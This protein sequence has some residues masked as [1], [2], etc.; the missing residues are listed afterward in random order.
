MMW[1][2]PSSR[3]RAREVEVYELV[4]AGQR[5]ETRQR[6]LRARD[7]WKRRTSTPR[8]LRAPDPVSHL[9]EQQC[10]LPLPSS[11]PILDART[12]KRDLPGMCEDE[13]VPVGLRPLKTREGTVVGGMNE[14]S[15]VDGDGRRVGRVDGDLED[16]DGSGRRGVGERDPGCQERNQTSQNGPP[17]SGE[18]ERRTN[19]LLGKCTTTR[20][21]RAMRSSDSQGEPCAGRSSSGSLRYCSDG[22]RN[23]RPA[24]AIRG[25][26]R[27]KTHCQKVMVPALFPRASRLRPVSFP[28][29]T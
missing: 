13:E 5:K 2:V 20:R 11:L 29:L 23:V 19:R 17:I 27:G 22:R 24:L 18:N 15:I 9:R 21:T 12:P 3:V 25:V 26:E 16:G 6:R 14:G 8:K 7:E 10:L 28:P 4:P 1:M